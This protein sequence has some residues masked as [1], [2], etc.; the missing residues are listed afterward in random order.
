MSR[1][2]TRAV[3]RH[4]FEQFRS[5]YQLP[6]GEVEYGD[7]PDVVIR[8]PETIGIEIARL[9]VRAGNDP[10]SE[11][12]QRVRRREVLDRAQALHL[13]TG[14]TR[15]ELSVDFQPERPVTQVEPVAKALAALA[16]RTAELPSGLIDPSLFA[17]TPEVR[18]VYRNA[19][20]YIDATW[21]AVQSHTVPSL[22][23]DRV[24]TVIREKAEKAQTYRHC[25]AYWLLLVVDLMD[26]AQDQ[27]LEW[28]AN[29][30]AVESP[31]ERVLLYKPQFGHVVQVP[32]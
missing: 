27:D 9:Y 21:R 22:A 13:S 2:S 24:R 25:N 7:K 28:P 14:G 12:V 16:D 18:L 31:F 1:P 4:Y 23:I 19:N 3:E 5:H 30:A 20:E 6:V 11:Q 10:A 29:G 15:I 8:G 17:D 32:A 26:R